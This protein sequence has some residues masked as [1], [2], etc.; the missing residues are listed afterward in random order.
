MA[1]QG[2][3]ILIDY[4]I[5]INR[6]FK[7]IDENLDA[8]ISL[9]NVSEIA[10]FSP[11]HFHRIFKLI[12]GE[13]LGEYVTRRRIERAASDLLHKNVPLSDIFVKYGFS[14]N[15]SFTRTFKNFYGVSPTDFRKQNPNKFSKISQLSSKIGQTYPD[16]DQ[17]ICIIDNLKNW[18]EMNAKIEV[19]NV[20]EMKLACVPCIGHHNLQHSYQKLLLWATPLDLLTEQTKMVTVYHDSFKITQ[21]EQ[22]RMDA[23]ML[24]NQ[25]V[26]PSGE[27]QLDTI[28]SGKFIVGSF[29]IGLQDFEK[30]WTGLFLWMNENGYKKADRNPFEVYH[31]DFNK[32]PEKKAI[33]DF[34]IPVV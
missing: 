9:A 6:V 29:E 4:R 26:K 24:L 19:R 31:N 15:S 13:A 7:Y 22:V 32:H 18:I 33:V 16:T 8:D 2:N 1:N 3:E 10:Y 11:F 34:Y 12:T 30:S 28:A 21:P 20:Q 5:R 17:Y 23:C 14:N 27:V 25:V